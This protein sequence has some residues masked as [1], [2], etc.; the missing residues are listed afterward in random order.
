MGACCS[1]KEKNEDN[2]DENN[3]NEDNEENNTQKDKNDNNNQEVKN[4]NISIENKSPIFKKKVNIYSSYNNNLPVRGTIEEDQAVSDL[5]PLIQLDPKDD[6][7]VYDM[8]NNLIND[9][10]NRPVKEVFDLRNDIRVKLVSTGLVL[11]T[12]IKD[13][14]AKNT[15]FVSSLSF[16]NSNKFAIFVYDTKTGMTSSYEYSLMIYQQMRKV[17]QF[18][19]YCN[20]LDKL[21]ISG[22]ELQSDNNHPEAFDSFLCIDLQKLQQR[23]FYAR[24]LP[25]LNT[26]RYWHSMIYVPDKYIF[27]VGG[28]NVKDVELYDIQK[29]SLSI[30]SELNVERCEPSLIMVNNK[31]LYAIC[32]FHLYEAFINSIERCNLHTRKRR[33]EIVNYQFKDTFNFKPSFFG[34]GYL[35]D[36]IILV[37]DK[38]KKEENKPNYLLKFDKNGNDIIEYHSMLESTTTRLFSEKLFIPFNIEESINIPFRTGEPKIYI[39]NNVTGDINEVSLKED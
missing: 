37:S 4:T 11:P 23:S 6:F 9:K 38:E 32:G 7:D 12:N 22:G 15:L 31:Y 3:E 34:V 10:F 20:A 27:I 1:S 25:P 18:S 26:K 21:Y 17:N 19:A 8:R 2:N 14:I 29:N 36:D 28:A 13:Y 24:E 39:L 33:W 30:D 35:N 16:D 5:I